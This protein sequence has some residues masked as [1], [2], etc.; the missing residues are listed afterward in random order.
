MSSLQDRIDEFRRSGVEVYGISVDTHFAAAAWAK[1]LGLT[2]P[3]LSD[4]NREGM[5]ALGITLDEFIGYRNISHRAIIIVDR[6][7]VVRYVDVAP[8]RGMPDPDAAL[9]AARALAH[10]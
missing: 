6:D 7:R 1:E 4:F 8:I 3:M 10:G 2:F 5:T 9:N